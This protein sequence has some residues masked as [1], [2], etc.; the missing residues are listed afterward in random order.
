LFLLAPETIAYPNQGNPL[1]F[2]FLPLNHQKVHSLEFTGTRIPNSLFW[3]PQRSGRLLPPG[4]PRIRKFPTVDTASGMPHK[5][6]GRKY[7]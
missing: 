4:N 6:L 3:T 2:Y 7:N 1:L 5:L